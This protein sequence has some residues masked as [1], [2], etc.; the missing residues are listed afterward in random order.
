MDILVNVFVQTDVNK[1]QHIQWAGGTQDKGWPS[2]QHPLP[3]NLGV[4]ICHRDHGEYYE[5]KEM[6]FL[7]LCTKPVP[8]LGW[9]RTA[10]LVTR[11]CWLKEAP[12]ALK[13]KIFS[14][15]FVNTHT[16]IIPKR[17]Y[18]YIINMKIKIP[19]KIYEVT[20]S[21]S[22]LWKHLEGSQNSL[23]FQT[24]HHA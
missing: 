21:V 20:T 5:A 14:L 22:K 10:D 3:T 7:V 6:F 1:T 18:M 16:Y 24:S 4:M 9:H 13:L 11:F 8:S 12:I 19:V 2:F 17:I 23:E 15:C